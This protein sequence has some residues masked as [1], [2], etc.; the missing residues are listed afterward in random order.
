MFTRCTHC[1]A[2]FRVTLQQLQAS[3]GQVRCGVC[4][5]VFDAF[6]HLTATPPPDPNA[7][8]DT[9]G[10]TDPPPSATIEVAVAL[11]R[12]A[13]VLHDRAGGTTPPEAAP[14]GPSGGAGDESAPPAPGDAQPVPADAPDENTPVEPV[15]E[16]A[17]FTYPQTP[18]PPAPPVE[19]VEA[20]L[21]RAMPET[22]TAEL[23]P[24]SVRLGAAPDADER[25]PRR[26]W[27]PT[28]LRAAIAALALGIPVQTFV[29]FRDQ[30]AT[31]LPSVRPAMVGICGVFGCRVALPRLTDRLVIES[32]DLQALDPARPNRV[33]LVAAIRNTA[34]YPQAFPEIELTLTDPQDRVVARRVFS[35]AD[36]LDRPD[37]TTAGMKPGGEADLRLQLDT[38][39]VVAAGYR[40]FLFHR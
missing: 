1:D 5:G 34:R 19:I 18:E 4:D 12:E 11:E 25:E 6:L 35:P 24:E 23:V 30:I 33:V 26:S 15:F 31:R 22:A 27:A 13:P 20:E 9:S 3:S 17:P 40:I 28:A 37:V 36:Y 8:A 21:A 7:Q 39:T 38:G 14:P 32:S 29:F 16:D 10:Q 2:I